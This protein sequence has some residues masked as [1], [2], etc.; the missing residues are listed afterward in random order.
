MNYVL[1]TLI[2]VLEQELASINIPGTSGEK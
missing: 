1:K 2:P